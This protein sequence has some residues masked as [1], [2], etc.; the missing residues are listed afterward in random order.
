MNMRNL[1]GIATLL[2]I[3]VL[4]IG[5][6][7]GQA[8]GP[9]V[10]GPSQTERAKP[11]DAAPQFYRLDF[12][13]RELDNDKV[14]NSRT[15]TSTLAVGAAPSS[16]RSGSRI[17]V[18]TG[19]PTGTQYQ[20]YDLGVNIDYRD[21]RELAAGLLTLTLNVDISSV[22]VTKDTTSQLPPVVRNTRW[23]SPVV[24][25]VKKATTVYSSDDASG[26]RKVQMQ[27]TATPL[28]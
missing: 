7:F 22:V 14:I 10:G 5:T 23:T 26:N 12:V 2:A 27:L 8:P 6:C 11:V 17:P 1:R 28:S 21:A 9:G 16:I 3:A 15:Y 18:A 19:S 13:V 24:V 20:Y 4:G 25:P